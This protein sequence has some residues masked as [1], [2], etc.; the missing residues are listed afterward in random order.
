MLAEAVQNGADIASAMSEAP[1]WR[2]P[3]GCDL[4]N[5]TGY[6][7]R[8]GLY[9]A[10]LV[11][12]ELQQAITRRATMSE[13]VETARRKGFQTLMEDGLLKARRGLTSVEEVMR[14]VGARTEE[15]AA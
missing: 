7:D 14:V 13:I 10:A 9:E 3:Q 12:S 15:A 5:Q 4:C 11:D 2:S 8:L 6:L 1:N